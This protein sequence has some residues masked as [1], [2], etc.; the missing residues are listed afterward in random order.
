MVNI[1]SSINC[2]E[3][4]KKYKKDICVLDVFKDRCHSVSDKTTI[5][6]LLE[7]LKLVT[8]KKN[9]F[10]SC[11][12]ARLLYSKKCYKEVDLGHLKHL[13]FLELEELACDKII[14]KIQRLVNDK[15]KTL[16]ET[17]KLIIKL[18]K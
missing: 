13:K 17:K 8:Y 5:S 3:D 7:I 1:G 18:K 2:K 6:D 15:Q 4:Y 16:N 9:I 11:R 12:K 14:S 10:N